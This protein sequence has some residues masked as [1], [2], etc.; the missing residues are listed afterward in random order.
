MHDKNGRKIVLG[1]DAKG[2]TRKGKKL[3]GRIIAVSQTHPKVM[4]HDLHK[5]VNMWLHPSLVE[6]QLREE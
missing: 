4:L 2:E 5:C 1:D 3:E 6:V